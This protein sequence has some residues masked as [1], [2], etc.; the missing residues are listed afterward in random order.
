MAT[1]NNGKRRWVESERGEGGEGEGTLDTAPVRPAGRPYEGVG[2]G[3]SAPAHITNMRR[4]RG[5]EKPADQS[6][7]PE[8]HAFL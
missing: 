4:G 3:T 1:E 6:T 5:E 2:G 8:Y 7:R